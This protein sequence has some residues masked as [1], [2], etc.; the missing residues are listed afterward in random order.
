MDN[1]DD[2]AAKYAALRAELGMDPPSAPPE[3]E[4]YNADQHGVPEPPQHEPQPPMRVEDYGPE[5]HAA[6]TRPDINEDPVGHFAHRATSL[7]F[8]AAQQAQI[9]QGRN[10][11]DYV[12][13]SEKTAREELNDYDDAVRHLETAHR[14]RIAE[15]FP[16][17]PHTATLAH[18][19]GLRSPA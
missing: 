19:Y 9:D 12:E 1:G 18:Q 4:P 13:R 17:S 10:I 11:R 15:M 7:E 5:H 16:D 2:D 3:A 6:T 14:R 8:Q